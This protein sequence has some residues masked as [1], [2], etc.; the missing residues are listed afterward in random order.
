M[1]SS[2]GVTVL[3][4]LGLLALGAGASDG[5]G[6]SSGV[7]DEPAG[8][9]DDFSFESDPGE[10]GDGAD[11]ADDTGGDTS[12]DTESCDDVVVEQSESG[13]VEVPGDTALF[14]SSTV[15]CDVGEGSDDEA[16]A[17]LQDALA[18]CNGQ[19]VAVDG[20]YGPETSQAVA[21]VQRE[22]G[23]T[24]DGTYDPETRRAMQ[25]PATSS[26]GEVTCVSD[27]DEAP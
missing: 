3:V 14:S 8:A 11:A 19:D 25:W 24:A 4:V 18:R 26:S 23:V 5:D 1:A 20:D 2:S 6:S 12:G 9:D 27:V 15:D 7:A 16:V 21:N 13:D 22:G 17:A 10:A